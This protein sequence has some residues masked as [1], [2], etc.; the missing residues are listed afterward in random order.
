[1]QRTNTQH[2]DQVSRLFGP[3]ARLIG[4]MGTV[5]RP[6]RLAIEVGGR[7]VGAGRTLAAAVDAASRAMSAAANRTCVS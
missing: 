1:M 5:A 3:S 7:V 6:G 2:E 4:S